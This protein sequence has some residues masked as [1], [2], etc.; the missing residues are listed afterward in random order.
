V[1]VEGGE[2]ATALRVW[3]VTA[4]QD[5]WMNAPLLF[6]TVSPGS[7][8]RIVAGEGAKGWM[9]QPEE[10]PGRRESEEAK[11]A[12]AGR[13]EGAIEV[14][15]EAEGRRGRE[16]AAEEAVDVRGATS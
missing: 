3:R 12:A 1:E 15:D 6:V 2:Q 13:P 11:S 10:R 9:A 16:V 7:T 8:A 4:D 14:L 5:E